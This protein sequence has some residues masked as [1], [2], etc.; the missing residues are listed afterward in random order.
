MANQFL[1]I[2]KEM[3]FKNRERYAPPPL[4]GPLK[5]NDEIESFVVVT[6]AL[7]KPDDIAIDRAGN[8]Y[9]S[10]G[11]RVMHRSCDGNGE[12]MVLAEFEGLAGGLNFHPNGRLMVCVDGKGL[13]L[14]DRENEQVWVDKAGEEPI[15]CPTSAI[16]GPDGKIYITDGS[17]YHNAKDWCYDLMK[18]CRTGR[19]ILYDPE[20][21][22]TEVLLSGLGYPYGLTITHDGLS[23][24]INE[25]WEHRVLSYPLEDIQPVTQKRV[26]PNLPGYPARIVPSSEGG[27]WMSLPA[28]R[29]HLVELVLT[30]GKFR[31]EMIKNIENP[32]YWLAPTLSSGNDFLEPLQGGAIRQLG[33]VKP[34]A[35]PRS[36]GL[37][38]KL[39]QDFD[40]IESYHSR[41][42]GKRHGITGLCEYNGYLYIVSKGDSLVLKKNIK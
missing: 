34:W 17:L 41:P 1:E 15:R 27:Y 2:L 11:N 33:I 12:W 25:S 32:E 8:L 38:I 19:L 13:V 36:Y 26:I 3:V 16:T 5:P 18:K 29:T 28:M 4:D 7:E 23:L 39:D 37:V 30:E 24:I 21:D 31:K 20:R 10:T 40:F 35:P 14:V 42:N 6:N 9:V 22:K